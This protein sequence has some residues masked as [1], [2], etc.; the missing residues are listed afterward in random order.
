MCSN[1]PISLASQ[2]EPHFLIILTR[3]FSTLCR[4]QCVALAQVNGPVLVE[5]TCLCFNALKGLP[6]PYIKWFMDKIGNDGLNKMLAGFE[7]H[8]GYARY[9][10]LLIC[11]QD[12]A[13]TIF[14][15]KS[16]IKNTNLSI[17]NYFAP[18]KISASL[19][20]QFMFFFYSGI[21]SL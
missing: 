19:P 7:D 17:C 15:N 12:F 18:I 8:S 9:F 13:R 3:R 2:N 4:G 20:E 14:C 5:D 6:G 21:S 16:R 10:V 1:F 11:K